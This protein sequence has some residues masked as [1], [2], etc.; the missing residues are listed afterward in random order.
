MTELKTQKTTAS[1]Q[2]F[3]AQLNSPAL[4]ADCQT[5]CSLMEQLTGSPATMW[6]KSIVGFGSYRYTY[7]S[8][9]SGDWMEIGFSPR[10]QNLTIYMMCGIDTFDKTHQ[11]LL[12][13][14]GPHSCG[15]SCLYVKRLADLNTDILKKLLTYSISQIRTRF[16]ASST[17]DNNSSKTVTS[18]NNANP[19]PQT[20]TTTAKK[21]T[22]K[23][24]T[25]KKITTKK[26]ADNKTSL[27]K[28]TIKKV[29][30]KKTSAK[31]VTSKKNVLNAAPKKR[32]KKSKRSK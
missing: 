7:A 25:A 26:T 31:K 32:V 27:K 12:Q 9:K 22:A 16:P 20:K 30:G 11:Q 6:G 28:K 15:S 2:N 23:K 13:Q 17:S 19:K 4:E 3:L 24:T 18:Q 29:P 14:I 8:G 21:T 1:V 5:L 10:K